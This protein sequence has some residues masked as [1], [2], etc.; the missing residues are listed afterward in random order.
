MG[1]A[2]GRA[3]PIVRAVPDQHVLPVPTRAPR[4]HRS[5]AAAA[6]H[7]SR[8]SEQEQEARPAPL[9]LGR[10]RCFF[11]EAN[12]CCGCPAF[13]GLMRGI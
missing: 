5:S 11:T 13:I 8:S 12:N 7:L 10:A 9:L 3:Q 6:G 2:P 4:A 1:L